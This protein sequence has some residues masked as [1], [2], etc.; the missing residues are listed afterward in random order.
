MTTPARRKLLADYRL[1]QQEAA[2]LGVLVDVGGEDL[3]GN[4]VGIAFRRR[5]A[6]VHVE[7]QEL[8]V[9]LVEGHGFLL[10]FS[11]R[12]P[13]ASARSFVCRHRQYKQHVL[14]FLSFRF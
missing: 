1:Y 9:R 7:L 6:V 2:G 12:L 14:T 4:A 10:C 3:L 8:Q 13:L 5:P 11:A